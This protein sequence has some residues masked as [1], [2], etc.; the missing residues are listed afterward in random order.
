MLLNK[1]H[2]NIGWYSWL[3]EQ[4]NRNNEK[5]PFYIFRSSFTARYDEC[6]NATCG[7]GHKHAVNTFSVYKN[8]I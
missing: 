2:K 6:D 7:L 8:C 1:L 3:T 4:C 5:I